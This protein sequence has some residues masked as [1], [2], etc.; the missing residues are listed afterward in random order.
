[1]SS[2]R[3]GNVSRATTKVAARKTSRTPGRL[4]LGR[5]ET[6]RILPL[7]HLFLKHL[8]LVDFQLAVVRQANRIAFERSRRRAFEVD[9]VLIKSAAVAGAFEL[10]LGFQPVGRAAEVGTDRTQRVDF[11]LALILGLADPHAELRFEFLL[12]D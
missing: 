5:N 10:L 4:P 12:H 9:A 3:A 6:G 11:H 1:M 2:T 8:A 7:P